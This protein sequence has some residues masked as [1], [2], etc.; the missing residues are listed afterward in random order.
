MLPSF[1]RNKGRVPPCKNSYK[2]CLEVP[3]MKKGFNKM[4]YSLTMKV[5]MTST[6]FRTKLMLTGVI[7]RCQIVE[8]RWVR[9]TTQN[10]RSLLKPRSSLTMRLLLIEIK[11]R[12]GMGKSEE[13]MSSP[14]LICIYWVKQLQLLIWKK[15][16]A[17]LCLNPLFK[18]SIFLN[19]QAKI[20][21]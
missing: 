15:D 7:V 12:A 21:L 18:T 2:M 3:V 16:P 9:H 14:S 4:I 20:R 1:Y 17:R 10:L 13:L 6:Q 19:L 8:L 5:V 11:W